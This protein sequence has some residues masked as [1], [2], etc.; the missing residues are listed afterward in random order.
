VIGR[1]VEQL[2]GFANLIR[3]LHHAVEK[4]RARAAAFGPIV[5]FQLELR[6]GALLVSRQGQPARFQGIDDKITRLGGTAKGNAQGPGIFIPQPPR[7]ILRLT[8]Q[9]V[10]AGFGITPREPPSGKVAKLYRRF[11]IDA[12]A[13]DVPGGGCLRVFF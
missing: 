5:H 8:A 7:N 9:V 10:I 12:P 4:L 2:N 1:E 6:G 3:K 11:T 13:F